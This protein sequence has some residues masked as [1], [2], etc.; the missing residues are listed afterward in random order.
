MKFW[1]LNKNILS[2]LI[3]EKI[4]QNPWN[5]Q[6]GVIKIAQTRRIFNHKNPFKNPIPSSHFSR[7]KSG[8]LICNTQSLKQEHERALLQHISDEAI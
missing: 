6:Y 1:E 2:W 5:R 3:A 4:V 8:A 7:L